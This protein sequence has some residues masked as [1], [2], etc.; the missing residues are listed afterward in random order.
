MSLLFAGGCSSNENTSKPEIEDEPETISDFSI[1][2]IEKNINQKEFE[3]K[4]PGYKYNFDKYPGMESVSITNYDPYD[5]PD[6]PIY[7]ELI[8]YGYV[9]L[10]S[11]DIVYAI[12]I[13]I[14]DTENYYSAEFDPVT[15]ELLVESGDWRPEGDLAEFTAE[16]LEMIDY[17]L[18]K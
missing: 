15:K 7:Q 17:V 13:F 5:F 16:R 18:Q 8:Q 10:E 1:E 12:D 6:L 9:S 3:K 4:Y 11:E 2:E 14:K